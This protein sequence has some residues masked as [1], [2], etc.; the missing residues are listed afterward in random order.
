MPMLFDNHEEFNE[1]FSKDIESHASEK[2]PSLDQSKSLYSFSKIIVFLNL[3]VAS[4]FQVKIV[5]NMILLINV[6]IIP[7]SS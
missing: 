7:W 1:W 3:I 2:K 6:N 5:E 4:N